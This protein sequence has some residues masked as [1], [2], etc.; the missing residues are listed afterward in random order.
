ME[1][2]PDLLQVVGRL[3]E[4]VGGAV[5]VV[6]GLGAVGL[7]REQVVELEAELLGELADLRVALVDQLPAVLG[8]LA[9]GEVVAQRPAAAAEPIGGLVE[10]G[11]VARLLQP[12]GAG[13]AGEAGADDHDPGARPPRS[14]RRA[15]RPAPPP[16]RA[17]R[18]R[19]GAP[20]AQPPAR[21]SITWSTGAPLAAA[22]AATEAA[23]LSFWA[24]GVRAIRASRPYPRLN[25]CSRSRDPQVPIS[26]KA[27][28]PLGPAVGR[29]GSRSA[30]PA[31]WLPSGRVGWPQDDLIEARGR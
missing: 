18:R 31:D 4:R 7:G 19:R 10:V 26:L 12:V 21:S 17:R 6:E 24:S 8:D 27:G 9:L 11:A 3:R 2:L 28:P 15:V 30:T 16:S 13:E 22:S 1:L 14:R 23:S 20:P 5:E 25:R 29:P